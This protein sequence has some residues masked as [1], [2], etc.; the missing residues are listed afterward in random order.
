[1]WMGQWQKGQLCGAGMEVFS[2]GTVFMGMY[3][4]GFAE[5][6]GICLYANGSFYE[7]QASLVQLRLG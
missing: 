1:M 5:G 3:S 4:Q 2:D 7:G 6:L